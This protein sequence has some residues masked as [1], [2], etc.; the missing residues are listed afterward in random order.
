MAFTNEWH[1]LLWSSIT[2]GA[3]GGADFLMYHHGPW[4][5]VIVSYSYV[6]LFA[7]SFL[8]IRSI[9][10]YPRLYRKQT[11]PLMLGVAVPWI[12]NIIYV[13][14]NSPVPGMDLSPFSFTIV[15]FIYLW[16]VFR[17]R[18]FEIVP[19]ARD[20][21]IENITE[22]VI[23]LDTMNR[24]ID[25]NPAARRF[26]GVTDAC[27]GKDAELIFGSLPLPVT[28]PGLSPVQNL[29]LTVDRDPE[30]VF[31]FD[32]SPLVD[33]Y[34]QPCGHMILMR[35]IT[36]QKKAQEKLRESERRYREHVEN[37]GDIVYVL[38]MNRNFKFTN[39]TLGEYI[40]NSFDDSNPKD[41][42]DS[43]DQRF[44]D[45]LRRLLDKQGSGS[46]QRIFE[47]GLVGTGNKA[48]IFEVSEKD[49]TEGGRIVEI[50][51]IGRDITERKRTEEALRESEERYRLVV[52][53]ADEGIIVSQATHMKFIN[54]LAVREL[55]YTE[56]ELKI[57]P[58]IELIHPDDRE[59]VMR[60][61]M[62]ALSGKKVPRSITYR[63]F[64]RK[65]NIRWIEV[66]GSRITWENRAQCPALR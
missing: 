13:S 20:L 50:H 17:T 41:F 21:L 53:N 19:I 52:E 26:L 4:F 32:I 42:K 62:D 54:P 30:R 33:R 6:T 60:Q 29:E 28:R 40:G 7:G 57:R 34:E 23:V 25:L 46:E 2:P 37:I 36:E 61:H 56:E 35:D 44:Y 47:V 39:S 55:G 16:S 5:W 12:A 63:I 1:W 18:L 22:G 31:N 38:D 27:I 3:P 49:I 14:G 45:N 51:G 10:K 9:A 58:F 64:D 65:G 59:M 66:I 43:I 24:V 15:G 8:L 11:A 48:R